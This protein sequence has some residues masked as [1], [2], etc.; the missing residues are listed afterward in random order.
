MRS[1]ATTVN[2]QHA[3]E[4][5]VKRKVEKKSGKRIG[6]NYIILKSLKESAKNDVVKC[7]YIKSITN[8][9]FCVIKEGTSGD[10]KDAEGRDIKDRLVWQK[11]LHELLQRKIQMPRLL[12]SFEENGN[13]YLVIEYIKGISLA[14]EC[15]KY[16]HKL[17]EGLLNGNE[18]GQRFLNYILQII[19]LLK[20]LHNN[21]IVHRD[22]T[23]NN[24]LITPRGKVAIIDLELSYSLTQQFPSPPFQL[25]THGYMSPQQI[26]TQTP[27]TYDDIFSLG[28]VL[29]QI[30]TN[31]SPIKITD[32]PLDI[33]TKKI[34]FFVP[35]KKIA[36]IITQCLHPEPDKR[37]NLTAVS[38][39]FS[40]YKYDLSQKV[41]RPSTV[42]LHYKTEEILN[43]IHEAVDTLSSPLLTDADSGWFAEDIKPHQ[44]IDKNKIK[45]AWYANYAYGASGIIYLLSKMKKSG[46]DASFNYPSI[47]KGLD[48]IEQKYINIEENKSNGLYYGSAGIAASLAIAIQNAL[49]EKKEKYIDWIN[50]LSHGK[51][52]ALGIANGVA[53]LGL[54]NLICAPYVEFNQLKERLTAYA[55]HLIIHQ[56]ENGSWTRISKDQTKRS[57][58]GFANGVAGIV[59][60]LLEYYE[61]FKN[62]EILESAERGLRWLIK[63]SIRLNQSI[64]WKSST[65]KHIQSL[66]S[67]GTPGISMAFLKAWK[68]TGL[69][70]YREYA[71]G[72]LRS[73]PATLLDNNLSQA[74][75]LSGLG[76]IYLEAYK[77]LKDEEWFVRADWIA[78]VTLNLMKRHTKYGPFWL[79][80]H[81]RQPIPGFLAGNSG[82]LHFLL[83]RCYPDRVNCPLLPSVNIKELPIQHTMD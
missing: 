82:V 45:K 39:I 76:E 32:S 28:A 78:Q 14:S 46:I 80:E 44:N 25:G 3:N 9:G 26:T 1:I 35:D 42:P 48:L 71:T 75:G 56:Q 20:D 50:K 37:P 79:V 31:I 53:G 18:T 6:F 15:K 77:I 19:N 5:D 63:N 54:A 49:L 60:F 83:R 43:I 36:E 38:E 67:E 7:L 33:L 2:I 24:F 62:E 34:T 10:S 23:S 81:E 57:T 17:R 58:R 66:W 16:G 30:W 59:Y 68:L 22:A 13:Y 8:F 51:N 69:P 41:Q 65:G 55:T 52:T 11:Q 72:A 27:T 47:Q 21:N 12:D 40:K 74:N 29:L 61:Q 64:Y 73:F 70:K 4:V